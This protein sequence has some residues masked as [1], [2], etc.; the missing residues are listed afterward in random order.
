MYIM[1]LVGRYNVGKTSLFNK[2]IQYNHLLKNKFNNNYD[3]NY[4]ILK[5]K[6]KFLICI[7]NINILDK[8][9]IINNNN[10]YIKL[11]KQFLFN[12]K[13]S[14]IICLVVDGSVGLLY[15]DILLYKTILKLKNKYLIL[16]I[17]KIDLFSFN[18]KII[19]DFYSLGIKYIVKISIYKNKSILKFLK[20]LKKIILY[21]NNNI[22]FNSLLKY[23]NNLNY[24]PLLQNKFLSK[25]NNN[26]IIKNFILKNINN[27]KIIII[28]KPNVGKSTLLNYLCQDYRSVVSEKENTT[29]DF[30]FYNFIIYNTNFLISDSP[31]IN[32]KIFRNKINI[33]FFLKK[34]LIF[35][36][37]LF[38]VDI[39]NGL[40]KYDLFLLKLFLVRGKIVFIIFNKCENLT[41]NIKNKFKRYI[42]NKYGFLK[43]INLFFLSAINL[44]INIVNELFTKIC[45]VYKNIINLNISTSL[46]N[47]ILKDAI[48]DLSENN[49]FKKSF[50]LKYAHIGNLYPLIIV[51][52]GNKINLINNSYK[53]YLINFYIKKLNFIG[54]NINIKFKEC[55]NPYIKKFKK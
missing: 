42:L 46:L 43:N 16:I 52:H 25:L 24:Y 54:Y 6:N 23:C 21:I 39:N 12:I 19:Y 48:N 9:K 13:N 14:D 17:N 15:E 7:D 30:I 8:K 33:N 53:K 5:L 28:G 40:S 31:G 20:I 37:I 47:R 3:I 36:V 29:K 18:E 26:I 45:L 27:I 32:K 34:I 35:K 4:G 41:L 51:I 10:L 38:L 44:N 11:Y 22:H 1:S 2:I 50:K 49:N 55:Y